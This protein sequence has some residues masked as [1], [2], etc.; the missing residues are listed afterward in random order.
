MGKRL[1]FGSLVSVGAAAVLMAAGAGRAEAQ[2]VIGGKVSGGPDQPLGGAVVSIHEMALRAA[3]GIAGTYSITIPQE[4]IHGQTVTVTV[5]M[6]GYKPET[7]RIT[8]VRGPQVQDFQLAVDPL[9]LNDIV[10]TGTAEATSSKELSFSVGAIAENALQDVPAV[11]PLRA[12]QGKIAGVTIVSPTG[13][14]GTGT[15]VRLRGATTLTPGADQS[16]LL[17][18]DG[19]ITKGT[20]ADLNVEDIERIEVVK[21]AAASSLYGSNAAAGVIQVFTRRGAQNAD[22]V[23]TV[24]IRNEYGK[25]GLSRRVPINRSHYDSMLPGGVLFLSNGQ[26]IGNTTGYMDEP[27]PTDRPWRDQLAKILGPGTYYT[28]YL[29]VARRAGATNLQ[30]SF[31]NQV[32]GGIINFNHCNNAVT[33]A[34]CSGTDLGYQRRN[35][36]LNM[37]QGIS[38]RLDVSVGGFFNESHLRDAGT[39]GGPFFDILFM[40][41]D[42]DLAG[43]VNSNGEPY[44]VN[45]GQEGLAPSGQTRNPLYSFTHTHNETDRIRVQGS[46]RARWR[47]TDWLSFEGSFGYD[48]S[49]SSNR[50]YTS[51][52]TLSFSGVPSTGSLSTDDNYDRAYNGQISASLTRSFGQLEGRL[53]FA[54]AIEDETYNRD[55]QSGASFAS[56]NVPELSNVTSPNKG[57]YT[58]QEIQRARNLFVVGGFTYKGRYIFDALI[59]RDGSSL[60]GSGARYHTYYRISGAYRLGEDLHLPGVQELKLRASVGTAGLR[61]P[62]EAQY[63]TFTSGAGGIA[64]ATL[65]NTAL[66]PAQSKETEYGI[67]AAFLDRFNIELTQ[68]K[69]VTSDQVLPVPLSSVAGFTQQWRNA[70]TLEGTTYEGALGV[71]IANSRDLS[72][73]LNVTF[74]RTRQKVT[75]LNTV[76]FATGSNQQSNLIFLIAPNTVYGSMWGYRFDRSVHDLLDNPANWSGGSYGVGTPIDTT[77]YSVNEDGMLIQSSTHG[78]TS[79]APIKYIDRT[80]SNYYQIGDANPTFT[81]S[82]ST[83]L[84]WHGFSVYG[85]LDWVNGGDIYNLPRQWMERSE[86]RTAEMDQAPKKGKTTAWCTANDASGTVGA[87][88]CSGEKTTNYYVVIN[89]ANTFNQWY[90]EDGSYARLRE[91]SVAYALSP[92]QIR[93]I[94]LSRLVRSVRV[95]INGRNLITWTKYLGLDPDTYNPIGNGGDATTFRFDSFNYPNFRTFSGMVEIG[96]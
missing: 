41:P 3:T 68:S 66:K 54:G 36:R 18:V 33:P 75:Q 83:N 87:Q 35:V 19:V 6:I 28:N 9:M 76:P 44:Q 61:P 63:E 31:E 39:G 4:R 45:I 51:K 48:R 49:Q 8:L 65:G 73:N 13:D 15:A 42:V 22:G 55:V 96:F 56:L 74:D 91:V 72:W 10:V 52:G 82:F 16:P 29:A 38:D 81:M 84:T 78:T 1:L 88:P 32:N 7:R 11:D 17:V 77:A 93:A 58:H 14:P 69:K 89:D 40:P 43:S 30:A 34:I 53:K 86:F 20:L 95:S 62:F 60:F 79:E 57:V 47:P 90:V 2:A 92:T 25:E 12:L 50:N 85:L 5:R 94:G 23:T 37:D 70:G 46:F 71:V 26:P 64:P 27:Y 67:D 80:G 24:T 59:R 21:G